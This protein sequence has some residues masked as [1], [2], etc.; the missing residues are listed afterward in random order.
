MV[1]DRRVC[2]DAILDPQ[3]SILDP[4][5]SSSHICNPYFFALRDRSD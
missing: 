3:S 5:R 1:E 4:P 2:D